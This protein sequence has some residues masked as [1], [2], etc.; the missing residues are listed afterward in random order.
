M[1]EGCS[2]EPKLPLELAS[3]KRWWLAICDPLPTEPLSKELY[4]AMQTVWLAGRENSASRRIAFQR[5]LCEF[6]FFM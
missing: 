4:P 6:V 3:I 1:I 2:V 5:R